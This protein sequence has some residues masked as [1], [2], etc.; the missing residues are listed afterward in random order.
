M[1]LENEIGQLTKA[2]NELNANFERFF[3]QTTAPVVAPLAP[4]APELAPLAPELA[5][6][7]PNDEPTYTHTELQTLCLEAT[8]RNPANRDIARAIMLN[9]FNVR[10]ASELKS[11]QITDCYNL[12]KEATK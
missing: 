1:S 11:Q 6:V 8:K 3:S 12:I 9:H 4:L 10:K 5:P 7:V 2:I